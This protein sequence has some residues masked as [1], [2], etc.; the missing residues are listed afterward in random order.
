MTQAAGPRAFTARFIHFA[1][2]SA[3]FWSML[4][5][6]GVPEAQRTPRWKVFGIGA[7]LLIAAGAIV[8]LL[9]W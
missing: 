1:I 9:P 5:G 6:V 4:V 3:I 2:E 8:A 7:A